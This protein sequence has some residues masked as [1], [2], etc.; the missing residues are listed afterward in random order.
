MSDVIDPRHVYKA[1]VSVVRYSQERA[2]KLSGRHRTL[3]QDSPLPQVF[4]DRETRQLGRLA[5]LCLNH[6]DHAKAVTF[7]GGLEPNIV[8]CDD[9][10]LVAACCGE[11]FRRR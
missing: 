8:A 5:V 2:H 1:V 6:P 10:T 11:D 9:H 4:S 7:D 3:R